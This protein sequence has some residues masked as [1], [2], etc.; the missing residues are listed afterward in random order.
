MRKLMIVQVALR[1]LFASLVIVGV[2]TA[3][4]ADGGEDSPGRDHDSAGNHRYDSDVFDC[5]T[6][7]NKECHPQATPINGMELPAH[8]G[9]PC[10][11]D[12]PDY[13][14][15]LQDT[16]LTTQQQ[17]T[18]NADRKRYCGLDDQLIDNAGDVRDEAAVGRS[19]S[20]TTPTYPADPTFTA[21][22]N[23]ANRKLYEET[24]KRL[25]KNLL[26]NDFSQETTERYAST[27]A[28]NIVEIEAS[29]QRAERNSE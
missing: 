12:Y 26:K 19:T 15:N 11:Q 13:R 28:L 24:Y 29:K 2:P 9:L 1:L 17:H 27:H 6:M 16:A 3:A 21:A 5:E 7:G 8:D 14:E 4:Q 25:Y 18:I 23:E 20:T 22:E 10:Y